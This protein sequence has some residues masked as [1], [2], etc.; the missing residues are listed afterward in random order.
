MSFEIVCAHCGAPSG[1][2]VGVCPFCK[3]VM[4]S[5]AASGDPALALIEKY[6]REGKLQ[7]ALEMAAAAETQ[8]PELCEKAEFS[9]LFA[10]ILIE[11]EGPAGK[12][13]GLL[14]K[15]RFRDPDNAEVLDYLEIVEARSALTK[16]KN[17]LG[18]QLL[19]S[20]LRRS[21][22]NVHALFLLGA[23]LFWVEQE[24]MTSLKLLE[25]CVQLRPTFLRAWGCL[26]A[27]YSKIGNKP[28]A[29]KAFQNCERMES[30]PLMKKFFQDQIKRSS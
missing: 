7:E 13:K 15:A 9:L 22:G 6:Y 12:I 30:D 4:S 24:P 11:A 27:I 2:S 23:H 25:S 19:R 29:L 5:K 28:L 10:K 14:T 26:G 21:P 3:S 18:E 17:D 20:L 1:P 16:E 8:K